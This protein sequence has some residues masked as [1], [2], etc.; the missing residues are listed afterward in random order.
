MALSSG[1]DRTLINHKIYILGV[2]TEKPHSK[3][4]ERNVVYIPIITLSHIMSH[5]FKSRQKK[6]WLSTIW[7]DD[8]N[9]TDAVS[10]SEE[11]QRVNV[12]LLQL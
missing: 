1:P 2:F 8:G 11:K 6:P 7:L 5:D 4:L 12:F 9:V 10:L 3:P